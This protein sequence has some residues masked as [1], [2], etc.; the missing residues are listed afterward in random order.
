L[1]AELGSTLKGI[2]MGGEGDERGGFRCEFKHGGIADEG[3][4]AE[5]AVLTPRYEASEL[6]YKDS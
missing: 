1:G 2:W 3:S 5:W 4:G 6:I